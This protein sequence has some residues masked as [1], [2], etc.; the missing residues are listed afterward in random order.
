[1]K[2]FTR[3]FDAIGDGRA[4]MQ[5]KPALA[6]KTLTVELLRQSLNQLGSAHDKSDVKVWLPGSK[7]ALSATLILRDGCIM[8][9]GNIEPDSAL[10]G[11]I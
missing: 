11:E 10:E 5:P 7:I 3:K 8:I 4:R 2:D 9:E 6:H 1:M